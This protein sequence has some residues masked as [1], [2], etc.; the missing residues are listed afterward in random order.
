MALTLPFPKQFQIDD[1]QNVLDSNGKPL[2]KEELVA[3]SQT[4]ANQLGSSN[5]AEVLPKDEEAGI[6]PNQPISSEPRIED[7]PWRVTK[8]DKFEIRYKKR[9]NNE[10]V[11]FIYSFAL[12]PAIENVFRGSGQNVPDVTPGIKMQT[13]MNYQRQLVPGAPPVYQSMGIKGRYVFLVGTFIGNEVNIKGNFTERPNPA[14]LD[15]GLDGDKLPTS[16][17]LQLRVGNLTR[18]DSHMRSK[19]FDEEIIQNGRPV[20]ITLS[21]ASDRTDNDLKLE[22]YGIIEAMRRYCVRADRTYYALTISSLQFKW[23]KGQA[24]KPKDT[25]AKQ[26]G[27]NESKPGNGNDEKGK[28]GNNKNGTGENPPSKVS[29]PKQWDDLESTYQNVKLQLREPDRKQIEATLTLIK[30]Y[31]SGDIKGNRARNI[32]GRQVGDAYKIINNMKP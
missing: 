1:K 19:I 17:E 29:I 10:D 9:M 15:V 6:L 4:L 30:E 21:A 11:D 14:I 31:K 25:P 24:D 26:P 20:T 23:N 3:L 8:F 16:K 27:N 32:I 12:L 2:S 5:Y 18:I 13:E 7:N 22:I 28:D